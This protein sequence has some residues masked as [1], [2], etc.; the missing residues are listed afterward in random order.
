M[1]NWGYGLLSG[2]SELDA[3]SKLHYHP[4]RLDMDYD[5]SIRT[6]AEI[7]ALTRAEIQAAFEGEDSIGILALAQYLLNRGI[8]PHKLHNLGIEKALETQY[9]CTDHPDRLAALQ[10][11]EKQY[12]GKYF[13]KSIVAHHN[14]G[15]LQRMF[16]ISARVPVRVKL[17]S[18]IRKQ[19][20]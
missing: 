9:A 7:H 18:I 15:L 19:N 16:E 6:P 13:S 3:R 2:D 14:R 12:T 5:A 10:E 8:T 20:F 1:G 17:P 11:F 4:A